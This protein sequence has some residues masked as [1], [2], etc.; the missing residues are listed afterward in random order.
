MFIITYIIWLWGV[1][2]L[3]SITIY[4]Q[5]ASIIFNGFFLFKQRKSLNRHRINGIKGGICE[6]THKRR[7]HLHKQNFFMYKM[8]SLMLLSSTIPKSKNCTNLS[9]LIFCAMVRG[10]AIVIV[11]STGTQQY[12]IFYSSHAIAILL[13]FF[14]LFSVPTK[15]RQILWHP[16]TTIFLWIIVWHYI[17]YTCHCTMLYALNS[18]RNWCLLVLHNE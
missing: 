17:F 13:V 6:A 8:L 2:K 16:E 9:Y 1:N 14:V 11:S 12:C 10:I 7:L 18:V 15:S 5:A 3:I 4:F